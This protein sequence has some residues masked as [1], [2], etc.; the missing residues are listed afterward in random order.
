MR[1]IAIF[2]AFLGFTH[3][4]FAAQAQDKFSL[5]AK[6]IEVSTQNTSSA[7]QYQIVTAS[8]QLE[9]SDKAPANVQVITEEQIRM[10]AY[11]SLLDVL[12]DLGPFKI[13]D[14]ATE[15]WY[16]NITLNGVERQ[17]KIVILL[18]G[19]RVSSPTNEPMHFLENYPPQLARQIEIIYGPASALYGADAMTG[20]INIITKESQGGL[21][22][23]AMPVMGSHGMMG[24]YGLVSQRFSSE[25]SL[26][27]GG[28]Y[29]LDPTPDLSQYFGSDSL[30]DMSG[31][32]SGTFQTDFG[33]QTPS[34]PVS[35]DYEAPLKTY[36][37][38][39]KLKLSNFNF[40]FFHN[41]GQVPT[42]SAVKPQNTVNNSDVFFGQS[43]TTLGGQYHKDFE[44]FSSTTTLQGNW[45]EVNPE[46]NFRNLYTGM[47][48]GYKY[49]YGSRGKFEQ[50]FGWSP[51]EKL[52]IVAGFSYERLSSLPKTADLD[53]P[54][55]LNEGVGGFYLGTELEMKIFNIIY[56]NTGLYGQI[57]YSPSE[58]IHFTL[59]TRYDNN[60]RF[61]G[62]LNPRLGVVIQPTPET[63][64][65]ALYGS[66]FLAPL[67][68]YSHG[69]YGSFYS[70]DGGETYQSDFIHAPNPDLNPMKLNNFEVQ[71]QHIFK[72]KLSLRLNGFFTEIEGLFASV[73]D[74]GNTNLYNGQFLGWDVGYMEVTVND[75]QQENWGGGLRLDYNEDF[76]NIKLNTWL[77]ANYVDGRQTQSDGEYYPV[78]LLST[79]QYRAGT[80]F[81]WRDF[82]AS[83]R[84][85]A[86]NAQRLDA[87]KTGT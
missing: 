61:G 45:Y 31:Q 2:I 3:I 6:D 85:I 29:T 42:S 15:D 82:T 19:L 57:Q 56:N 21:L 49:A 20:V 59:G 80:D 16:H 79:W 77:S 36:A 58:K 63:S 81:R 44:K 14:A 67:P 53:A 71:A 30:F 1:K 69:H 26:T 8:R 76:G 75:N 86:M 34:T 22:V 4:F 24:G 73:G 12:R 78:G 9:S 52:D 23:E 68:L 51:H 7:F 43:V 10:R 50:Q 35:P 74:N 48:F 38:F 65:K 60:S 25:R 41:Y 40:T 28:Q 84:L 37:L 17:D 13:D 33:P 18:D 47:E 32:Q 5:S 87:L 39:G 64:L 70:T 83:A 72:R 62:T 66:A 46:S 27:L 11:R 55:D 54:V